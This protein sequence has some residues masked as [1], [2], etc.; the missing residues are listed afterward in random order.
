MNRLF[1]LKET[2][3]YNINKLRGDEEICLVNYNS[4]DGLDEYIKENFMKEIKCGKLVYFYTKEPK[5][6]HSSISKNLAVR[7]SSGKYV[8]NLDA[9]NWINIRTRENFENCIKRHD[10]FVIREFDGI[11]TGTCGRV[12]C[13]RE[14]YDMVGGYDEGMKRMGYQ[15]V[16]FVRCLIKN[17][18]SC[19]RFRNIDVLPI[20]HSVREKSKNI[21]ELP[22]WPS[23]RC[24]KF[25]KKRSQRKLQRGI[26]TNNENGFRKFIGILNFDKEVEI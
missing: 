18:H 5:Y 3:P 4:S 12:G 19:V 23:W 26:S 20:Q 14:G 25:N 11:G 22:N 6:F 8:F 9:D 15:D 13:S 2:L 17:G 1:T 16:D 7:L 21:R 24:N 10:K